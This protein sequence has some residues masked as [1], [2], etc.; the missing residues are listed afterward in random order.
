MR[1][2]LFLLAVILSVASVSV[3]YADPG[4]TGGNSQA[5]GGPG[6]SGNG[7]KAQDGGGGVPGHK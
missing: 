1:K 6:G 5:G 3:A 7:D 2:V 4:P